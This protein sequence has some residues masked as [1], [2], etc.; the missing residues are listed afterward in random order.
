MKLNRTFNI[1]DAQ[2][3]EH[4]DVI[5]ATLP[6]DMPEFTAFDPTFTDEYVTRLQ[7]TID[8][9]KALP[10]DAV[11]IDEMAEQTLLVEKAMDDCY[12]DYKLLAY[13]ARKAFK[14]NQAIRNQFGMNDIDK[15]RKNQPKMVVFMESLSQAAARYSGQLV[16]SGC[17]QEL[18]SGLAAKAAALHDANIAQ[19]KFKTERAL[20]TQNRILLF[21]KINEMLQPLHDAAGIMYKDNPPKL[22][23][24]TMP[25]KA[26]ITGAQETQATPESP[27]PV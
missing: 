4:A 11:L 10:T 15:V 14:S 19:E 24:Y 16:Q 25:K 27:E 6:D 7:Q 18:I 2:M 13:F 23:V 5:A 22:K 1:S 9:A 12:E 21:N 26:S 8:D 17:S 3:L 20:Q